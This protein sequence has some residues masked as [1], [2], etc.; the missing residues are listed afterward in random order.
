MT[1]LIS[2]L[3]DSLKRISDTDGG[4]SRIATG[5]FSGKGADAVNE[6]VRKT[7][8]SDS[9]FADANGLFARGDVGRYGGGGESSDMIVDMSPDLYMALAEPIPSDDYKRHADLGQKI[10]SGEIERFPHI[11]SLD[12]KIREDGDAVITGHDGRH[13]AAL[14]ERMG[15]YEIPV[16]LHAVNFRWGCGLPDGMRWP[17][18]LWCQNDT[19]SKRARYSFRFPVSEESSGKRYD[20][21]MSGT[22][23]VRSFAEDM[24]IAKG[25]KR[26]PLVDRMPKGKLG[27][28]VHG[29]VD[30]IKT[31]PEAAKH[32][33]ERRVKRILEGTS[34][35]ATLKRWLIE[36][37]DLTDAQAELIAND[38][39]RKAMSAMKRERIGQRGV[40]LVKW[41][42]GGASE[43]RDYH[44]RK[45]DG[46]SGKR[47]GHP[48]GLNGFVFDPSDPPVIDEKTGER[49]MPGDL[50]NC[51]CRLVEVRGSR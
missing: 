3:T 16:R 18:V 47:N 28:I 32:L 13:R 48:N 20:G 22:G 10:E 46:K 27:E 37:C 26:N 5:E 12:I 49:G 11:P 41:V 40:R 44:L 33:V 6:S 34:T 31:I 51:H 38:Q 14:S 17:S 39:V 4:V 42:H 9:A 36:Q 50:I 43:P 7:S 23:A 19:S 35:K 24:A 8:A 21:C 15:L 45:W 1:D 29:T 25:A 2:A 30:L